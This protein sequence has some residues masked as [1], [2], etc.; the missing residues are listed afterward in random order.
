MMI[1]NIGV[2]SNG[3]NGFGKETVYGLSLVPLPPAR[4]IALLPIFNPHAY[5]ININ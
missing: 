4:I 1:S 3:T 2:S 5:Y